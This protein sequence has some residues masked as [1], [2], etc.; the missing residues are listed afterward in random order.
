MNVMLKELQRNVNGTRTKAASRACKTLREAS[1]SKGKLI[2]LPILCAN[3]RGDG[4]LGRFEEELMEHK[5]S[6]NGKTWCF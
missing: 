5:K 3:A 4:L 1:N 2:Y 6:F